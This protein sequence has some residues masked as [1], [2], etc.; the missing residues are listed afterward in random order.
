MVVSLLKVWGHLSGIMLVENSSNCS[1]LSQVKDITDDN[2]GTQIIFRDVEDELFL[3]LGMIYF[4]K[5]PLAV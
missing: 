5:D 2:V 1:I 4:I 3:D